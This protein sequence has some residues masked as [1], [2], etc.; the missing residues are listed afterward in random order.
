MHKIFS[1]CDIGSLEK[2][3]RRNLIN[4]LP[5]LKPV[6]LI[7]TINENNQT[8]LAIF[9]SVHHIGANPPL[10]DFTMRPINVERHTWQNIEQTRFFTINSVS[11]ANVKKHIKL[12]L[13]MRGI[14]LNLM[15]WI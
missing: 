6:N 15:L 1:H 2:N 13:A 3:Y 4:S 9:A 7:G 5:G 14:Y 12:L 11:E 10:M 8:N